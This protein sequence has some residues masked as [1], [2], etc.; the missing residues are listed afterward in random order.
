M[1]VWKVL[2]IDVV[3]ADPLWNYW[4]RVMERVRREN[5]CPCF[6]NWY[7]WHNNRCRKISQREEP[8]H[9]G[10]MMIYFKYQFKSECTYA[11]FGK[12]KFYFSSALN[13]CSFLRVASDYFTLSWIA[14]WYRANWKSCSIWRKTWWVIFNN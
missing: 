2:V 11:S 12:M 8:Q 9:K 4:T 13:Y 5:R 1:V 3:S 10:K 7:W 6:R 14:L